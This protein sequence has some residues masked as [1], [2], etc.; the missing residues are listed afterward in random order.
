ML[1]HGGSLLYPQLHSEHIHDDPVA[2][3][4]TGFAAAGADQIFGRG[5]HLRHALGS[6]RKVQSFFCRYR[7]ILVAAV[8]PDQAQTFV[9]RR[10]MARLKEND[11]WYAAL[12]WLVI[13][14]FG[15]D[16]A[17]LHFMVGAFLAGVVMD[18][19]WFDRDTLDTLFKH[20]LLILMPVF[21]LSTGLRTK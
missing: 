12:I 14:S 11:R 19:E 7:A 2:R 3:L 20:V 16:W 8:F 15:S 1:W 5:Q 9:F 18:A 6:G 4:R 17:G 21:F 10:I 13:C